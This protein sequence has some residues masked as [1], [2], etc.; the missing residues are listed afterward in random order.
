MTG[1]FSERGCGYGT[2]IIRTGDPISSGELYNI[3]LE[4]IDVVP[5]PDYTVNIE[6][7][8]YLENDIAVYKVKD[9]VLTQVLHS[10][11]KT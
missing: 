6:K 7:S 2:S 11:A 8:A 5:H 3:I 4:I 9:A 10:K 1:P